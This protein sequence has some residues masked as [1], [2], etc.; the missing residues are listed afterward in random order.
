[1]PVPRLFLPRLTDPAFISL[2]AGPVFTPLGVASIYAAW[3]PS[4][5]VAWRAQYLRRL[6]SPVFTPLGGA[7]V[8]AA[9]Q[10]QCLRRLAG[11]VFTPLGRPIV[12]A[13]WQAQCLSRLAGSV[14]TPLGR[15]SV[16]LVCRAVLSAVFI[17]EEAVSVAKL[18][19]RRQKVGE[20][21][22]VIDRKKVKL[23]SV[24]FCENWCG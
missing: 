19:Y 23:Y 21:I 3:R 5:Y 7:S 6:A 12:Y 18:S 20:R 13:A 24:D 11:P 17:E 8:Y 9:W 10:A 22:A 14:M 2:S 16:Y 15:G 1:M 4:I